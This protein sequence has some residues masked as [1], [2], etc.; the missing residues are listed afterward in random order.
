MSN[1][2]LWFTVGALVALF[3]L[4]AVDADTG[5]AQ[6][7]CADYISGGAGNPATGTLIGSR[8][9]TQTTTT[10][11]GASAGVS[12]SVGVVEGN[13]GGETSSSTT[14][15]EEFYVGTYVMFPGGAR[16]EVRCDTYVGWS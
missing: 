10:S 9:V 4:F 13:A 16:I 12:G 11:S 5:I 7:P 3:M 15:T 14:T 2:K 6:T 8:K 1:K